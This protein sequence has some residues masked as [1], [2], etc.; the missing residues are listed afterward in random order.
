MDSAATLEVT[1]NDDPEQIEEVGISGKEYDFWG[2]YRYNGSDTNLVM[3]T[4]RNRIYNPIQLSFYDICLSGSTLPIFHHLSIQH[5]F[6]RD[7]DNKKIG[8]IEDVLTDS[9]LFFQN[10]ASKYSSS[11]RYSSVL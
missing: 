10:T 11:T 4:N 8:H 5:L 1:P 2:N 6:D 7:Q 9:E 3:F